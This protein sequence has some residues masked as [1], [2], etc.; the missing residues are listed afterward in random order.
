MQLRLARAVFE[1]LLTSVR[2]HQNLVTRADLQRNNDSRCMLASIPLAVI[3]SS[4]LYDGTPLHR[5]LLP[6]YKQYKEALRNLKG[7]LYPTRV[8][9]T[10]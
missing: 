4:I 10:P 1:A 2:D 8:V 5:D 7:E 3:S 6:A 9:P